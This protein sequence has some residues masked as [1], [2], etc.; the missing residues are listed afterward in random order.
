MKTMTTTRTITF[1]AA[2]VL[3]AMP[4]FAQT[5]RPSGDRTPGT[6]DRRWGGMGGG[7]GDL[8]SGDR[9]FRRPNPDRNVTNEQWEEILKFMTE[10]SPRRTGAYNEMTEENKP[11]VKKLVTARY[12]F[13]QNVKKDDPALYEVTVE[14]W[15]SEDAIF[16]ILK[17]ARDSKAADLGDEEKKA[18]REQVTK[19]VDTN[20]KERELRIKKAEE[21]LKT[22]VVKLDEDK[23]GKEGL[24]EDKVNQYLR[25]G[26]RPLKMERQDRP[27]RQER[28]EKT[29]KKPDPQAAAN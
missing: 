19:L 11:L 14:K 13:I 1:L 24:I 10:V 7:G 27:D 3:T 17:D 22:A 21:A 15:K 5:S 18:L 29:D 23:K 2:A 8:S 6:G 9:P 12:D 20:F 26:A 4:A 25:E 16:G 28:G